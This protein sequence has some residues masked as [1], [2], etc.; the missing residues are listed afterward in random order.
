MKITIIED[1]QENIESAKRQIA[2]FI[3]GEHEIKVITSAR[4]LIHYGWNP[5]NDISEKETDLILSDLWLQAGEY[6]GYGP[7]P[8]EGMKDSDLVPVGLIVAMHAIQ[9]GIPCILCSDSNG[10][11][12]LLGKIL[13]VRHLWNKGNTLFECE[14]RPKME[15]GK[16][17]FRSIIEAGG[18]IRQPKWVEWWSSTR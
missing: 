9:K 7:G 5:W 11:R 18:L 3:P 14:T 12:D 16:D 6:E 2:T 17:W 15:N 13:E 10:H 8:K 1:K 4:E